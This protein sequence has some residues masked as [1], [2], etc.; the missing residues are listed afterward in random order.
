MKELHPRLER[1]EAT[2]LRISDREH[3]AALFQA[4]H[5]DVGLLT[6]LLTLSFSG[7]QDSGFAM[8]G[9]FCAFPLGSLFQR[10]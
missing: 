8:K 4:E 5:A 10:P 2:L 3:S 9:A 6:K 1:I 7:P